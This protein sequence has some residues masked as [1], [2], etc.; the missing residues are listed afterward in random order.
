MDKLE[1]AAEGEA[2][3]NPEVVWALVNDPDAYA[4]WGPWDDGGYEDRTSE[5]ADGVG[6]IRWYR[7]GRTTSVEK[8]LEVDDGRRLVYTVVKG[9]PVRNYRAEVTLTPTD[10]GTRVRWAATWDKTM[11]GRIVQRALRKFYPKMM[12]QLVA[13]AELQR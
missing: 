12:E 13:A 5:S 6:S 11:T 2:R 7:S 3:V 1:V 4:K 8:I 9:I 10:V